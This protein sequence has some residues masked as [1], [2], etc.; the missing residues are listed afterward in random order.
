MEKTIIIN[1]ENVYGRVA[2][3]GVRELKLISYTLHHNMKRVYF[4]RFIM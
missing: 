4:Y 2:G 1:T 3:V